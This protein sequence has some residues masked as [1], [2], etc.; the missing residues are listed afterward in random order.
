MH[1]AIDIDGT[2][3]KNPKQL[4]RLINAVFEAHHVT[5]LTGTL[6]VPNKPERRAQ[7]AAL[8]IPNIERI[9]I[10]ICAGRSVE[11]VAKLKGQFC[12]ERT[13]DIL[14]EDTDT[15]LFYVKK[16]SPETSCFKIYG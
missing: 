7:V 4:G 13:V 2:L 14:F 11:D 9:P 1:I 8:G 16:I 6:G 12:K 3:T 10:E 5:F 15:Y